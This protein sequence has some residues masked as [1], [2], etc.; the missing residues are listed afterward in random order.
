MQCWRAY[1][2][3]LYKFSGEDGSIVFN[4]AS[5]D[6]HIIEGISYQLLKFFLS[7]EIFN[8]NDIEKYCGNSIEGNQETPTSLKA[9][10]EV[11]LQKELI[12]VVGCGNR[13]L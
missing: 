10:L 6:T 4:Q 2:G 9:F 1:P 7:G 5:G 11:L 12:T 13:K 3:C 8:Y